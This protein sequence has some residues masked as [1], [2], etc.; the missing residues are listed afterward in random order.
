M[1][2]SALL[3]L[4][5][6]ISTFSAAQ[7]TGP[8]SATVGQ[9]SNFA[10]YGSAVYGYYTWSVSP[11]NG[12]VS[13]YSRSGT[14]YYATVVWTN[15]GSSTVTLRGNGAFV[16][17]INVSI[18]CP[19]ATTPNASFS[20][21]S[22][23]CGDKTISYTGN[24]PSGM[25]WYW[26][27]SSTGTSTSNNS[28]QIIATSSGYYY[29]RGYL[30]CNGTWTTAQS[31]S[32]VTVSPIPGTGTPSASSTS[33]CG[34]GTTYLT[35][36]GAGTN[37]IY[38]WYNVSSGGSPI[39]QN[40]S[41][42]STTT[43]Y[44][45][46]Y[47]TSTTC[48]GARTPITITVYS[49]PIAP[50]SG[51]L[52]AT[53]CGAGSVSW[54][55]TGAGTNETYRWYNVSGGG[56]PITPP[57]SVSTTT[58]LYASIYNS[59]TGCEG[60]RTAVTVT[61]NLIPGAAS[62]SVSPLAICGTGSVSWSA[63]GAGTNE[64][65]R[66]YNVLTGG[67]AIT[68][69][70]SISTSTTLYVSMYNTV[71]GCEGNRSAVTATVNPLPGLAT[72]NVSPTTLCGSGS[73]SWSGSGAGAYEVYRWYAN[74]SGGST[75]TPAA[76]ISATTTYY[77]SR[78]NTVT[79]CEGSRTA[80]TVTINTLP[81]AGAGSVSPNS[82][83]GSGSVTWSGS[84]AGANEVYRWYAA[85]S[86]GS[87]I[88]PA[89]SVSTTTTNYVSRYNTVTGCEGSRTAVTVTVNAPITTTP[90][91]TGNASFGAGP[92]TLI[93]NGNPL[94]TN[95]KWY[96]AS[97]VYQTTGANFSTSITT[98]TTN[99]MYARS[100]STAG[101]E[102]PQIA[103][104]VTVYPLP[105]VTAPQNYVI[106]DVPVTLTATAGNDTYTWKNSANAVVGT[107]QTFVTSLA[108]TYTVTVTKSGLSATSAPFVLGSQFAGIN[109]NYIVTNTT[110]I[111]GLTDANAIQDL[112][113]E[114]VAQS[115]SYFDGLGRPVQT[116]ATQSSVGKQDMVSPFVYDAFGREAR[117]YLPVVTESNGRFKET[118]WDSSGNYLV[119]TYNNTLDKIADDNRP[120]SETFFEASP[121]NRPDKEY[122]AGHSWSSAAGGANKFMQ[123]AYLINVH[124]TGS[125]ATQEKV[126]AWTV[127][128]GNLPVRAAA[129]A[130]YIVIGGYYAS[131]Q[132]QIKST[133]DEEGNEV[134][135]YT[136]KLGRVILKKVQ[137][138]ASTDLNNLTQWALTYYVYDDLGN[139]RL[140]LPPEL[141]KLIHTNAD[142]YLVTTTD[143][144]NWAFQYKYDGR[145]RM[146][147]KRVPG[148]DW[149]YMVYDQRDRPVFTQ[150]GKQRGAL[151]WTFSK[152]DYLNRPIA[153]GIKDTSV[154]LTQ[155]Q[156]QAAVDAYYAAIPTKPWR[157]FGESFVGNVAGNVHG[158][159]N[160]SYPVAFTYYTSITYY[161]NYAFRSL[162]YGDY[163]YLNENLSEVTNG[164]TYLQP[165]TEN[166]RV[167]GQVM[168]TKVRV[169]DG[170]FVGGTTWLKSIS[171]YDDKYRIVQTL[172]DNY[173]GGTDRVTNVIDFVGKVLKSKSTHTETDVTWKDIVAL[174]QE[175]NK[176]IN[177]STTTGW[178]LSGA[179]SIQQLPAGQNG[180]IEFTY[181][182]GSTE[183]VV[184]LSSSN[185]N[186]NFNT[187]NFGV[188]IGNPVVANN[189]VIYENGTSKYTI[190]TQVIVGDVIRVERTGTTITYKVNGQLKYTSLVSS[191]SAL[192][193][194]LSLNYLN[195]TV[196]DVRSSFSTTTTT[197]TR[198]FEYDHAGRLLKT[199]H[200]LDRQPEILLSFNEYNELGQLVDKKLHSTVSTGANAKQ[201]VDYRYN[202]RGW[203][204][205]MNDASL[206]NTGT[207]NDDT[208]D[209]YGMNLAYNTT[210]LGLTN[211]P[212]YNGNISGM[213]WS[214]NL[215]LGTT[216]Q[217]G[218][219]YTYDKL[220]RITSSAFKEKAAG[221]IAPT[222]NALAETGFLYDL[223]GNI[224][225]LQRNDRRTSG[226]MDNLGYTYSGNKLLRVT[227]SGDDYLGFVDGTNTGDDYTYDANG[228]MITDLNKGISTAITYNYLNLPEV[229][230]KGGN[231][232]R[233]IY[234][235]TG[236]KL[237]QTTS[238]GGLQKQVDYAGEFQYENDVLQF[239]SHEEGRIAIANNKTI[240]THSGDA[241]ANITAATSTLA[242]V[243]QN[244]GQAY[245]RAIAVGTTTKQGMFPIGGTLA[246][247]AGEQYRIRAKGYRTANN[248][249]QVH[250]YIRTNGTDLNWPGAQIPKSDVNATNESYVEQV[251]T[252]PAGHTTLEAGVVWNTVAAGEQFFLNDFEITR[253]ATNTTPEYQYN[254]K[255][256]L[257]NV[258]LTFTTKD[259]VETNTATL[260]TANMNL[261]Q[262]QFLR[263]TNAKRIQASLFDRT[264]GS[265]PTTTTGYSVRLNG[266]ANEKYGLAKS[267]SVMPGDVINTEVYAKYVDPTSSNWNAML[268]TLMSQIAAGT[269]GVVV[270]GTAYGSSTASFPTSYGGLVGKTDNG[271]PK[272]YLN[273]LVFDRNFVFITGG[274]KQIT[275]AGK[276]AGTDVP[277][278]RVFNTSPI[279][280]T[281][282]GYVYIYLS[283]ENLTPVE[284]YFDDFKVIHTKS[285][286]IQTDEYYPFGLTFN[287]YQRENTTTSKYLYNGKEKQDELGLDWFD[288]GA[289]MYL[290]E[291]GRWI[292]IDPLSEKSRR[293]STYTYCYNSPIIFIDPDGMF[294]DYYSNS[295]KYLG[296][297]GNNDKKIYTA[298]KAIT[299]TA[300]DSDGKETTTTTFVNSKEIGEVS[301]FVNM[302]GYTVSSEETKQDLVGLSI[303]LRN[304]EGIENAKI[305]VTGG[306]RNVAENK[307]KGGAEG[308]EHTKGTAA[309]IM[310]SGISNKKLAKLT[311]NSG[312]FS[313][314]IYYP[315]RG[316][317]STMGTHE[318]KT[319]A[320]G[321]TNGCESSIYKI[322]PN[323]QDLGPHVHVDNG[324]DKFYGY[325]IGHDAKKNRYES[326]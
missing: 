300:K 18:A 246:V 225:Q 141:S 285:P 172:S 105:V 170:G 251:I 79:G 161:D 64:A 52:P 167:I 254:L 7:M 286:V 44:M 129:L 257:G 193:A 121:L 43:F 140:V 83:C 283:N 93:G 107:S 21:S 317:L 309:D 293:W 218:Y 15:S 17:S 217:N 274:F 148:A 122:G 131:G 231:T 229:V 187:I 282:P 82:L 256:H 249:N 228:N 104:N 192:L 53:I 76:G 142:T 89:T 61:V 95:Y 39:A 185:T 320:L 149:V 66:W 123:H 151:Q 243:T 36:T 16:S 204:T 154:L 200:K 49:M 313:S 253:L 11:A 222:N 144:N 146:I 261:E 319:I 9:S 179:A 318:I 326:Y 211:T 290:P 92:I 70:T 176:V 56:S 201:S 63:S 12:Y 128:A 37:E 194:D 78:Y 91:I 57:T 288:Y 120:F 150:D 30:P 4:L 153:T 183:R 264:N 235:A 181:A 269:A 178:G 28:N 197:T 31:T 22:N 263:Y 202:I 67:S 156:M 224:T 205:S 163:T 234:D 297:D 81:G 114:K 60:S 210:D 110:Q 321:G 51:V 260:E 33:L 311:N 108:N 8:T 284:V 281:Q 250:L 32:Y 126:I 41:I 289:R 143:L 86:G 213:A 238:F 314:V 308:S 307:K 174:K 147:E 113:A 275:T 137:A 302:N 295:G 160:K 103:I 216:K 182:G 189:A 164:I 42:S 294:G 270:D 177:T 25:T 6:L 116:V 232:I 24:A 124:N 75:I 196:S 29:L 227:D 303:Y 46:V 304:N 54:S 276:E 127:S 198:R 90:T 258:R 152:Y 324:S 175:G 162:W 35:G 72:G 272:A 58:T 252:I 111:G 279:T 80:V 171:Y 199:W 247:Q 23:T 266:S 267:L 208:G 226:W 223:N 239:I 207:T 145:K 214:N 241:M 134:R 73:V 325:Y 101:C 262:S 77:V 99:F 221:W 157:T 219:T 233:Y 306:D 118:L 206:T 69:P 87:P 236:R 96:N 14:I 305:V 132:L 155:S 133:K 316:D 188:Y 65:Y 323:W 173:K 40:Q 296:S 240:V 159:S 102:G 265:A 27:T 209:L 190:P 312:L 139:L 259:E 191:N 186:A 315:E 212:L 168:G 310:V 220:N 84:G 287:S 5:V 97:N 88:T 20:Y 280:I 278:E 1:K 237:A 62:G 47:N 195:S 291:I 230:T 292:V 50:T 277:H 13:T 98:T 203:L 71:T 45:A 244:G 138:A 68:P 109:K 19:S 2:N 135:E 215:G 100:V 273:W 158:Y 94:G 255:D 119:N 165:A 130:G 112:S 34:P 245:I 166:P 169:L 184:G 106:K 271:A 3:S 136:D 268:T 115:I 242:S 248:T 26:Q 59:D 322:V 125:S 55:A 48:E 298:D 10:Y 117:K 301:D 299:N 74:S 38:R 85:S 180:W